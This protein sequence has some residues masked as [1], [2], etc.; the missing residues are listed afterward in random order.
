MSNSGF[1]Q[2]NFS[3]QKEARRQ[4]LAHQNT[5]STSEIKASRIKPNQQM[6]RLEESLK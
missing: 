2:N 6:L 1:P 4:P 3:N 5:S